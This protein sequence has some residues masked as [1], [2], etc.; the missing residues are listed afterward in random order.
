MLI[1]RLPAKEVEVA[2]LEERV[3]RQRAVLQVVEELWKEFEIALER[4]V[5]EIREGQRLRKVVKVNLPGQS[6]AGQVLVD[7]AHAVV[8][9][10]VVDESARGRAVQEKSIRPR[11]A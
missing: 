9:G 4:R 3:V 10:S 6:R 5:G 8:A 11:L 7:R 1:V 2:R